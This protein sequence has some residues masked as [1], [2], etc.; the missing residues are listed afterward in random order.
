MGFGVSLEDR[1]SYGLGVILPLWPAKLGCYEKHF[2][3]QKAKV[4]TASNTRNLKYFKQNPFTYC[5]NIVS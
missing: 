3:C 1:I 5:N 2:V 4:L